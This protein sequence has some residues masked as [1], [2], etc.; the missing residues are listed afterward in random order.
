MLKVKMAMSLVT[1][2]HDTFY[3]E[4][5][6]S[7]WF[8]HRSIFRKKH[9]EPLPKLPPKRQSG[10]DCI[11]VPITKRNYA[12]IKTLIAMEAMAMETQQTINCFN[13]V[14]RAIYTFTTLDS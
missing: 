12:P 7:A 4:G 2:L 13:Y 5:R 9:T 10:K 11:P 3:C 1:K 14:T 8:P 6:P